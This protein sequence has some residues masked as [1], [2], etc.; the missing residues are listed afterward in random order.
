MVGRKLAEKRAVRSTGTRDGFFGLSARAA[1]VVLAMGTPEADSKAAFQLREH[2][3]WTALS[4]PRQRRGEE[5][6]GSISAVRLT[7]TVIV[8]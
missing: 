3:Q 7:V 8:T 6:A 1:V 5:W 2:V 4:Q